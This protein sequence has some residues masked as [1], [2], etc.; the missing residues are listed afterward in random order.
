MF[1]KFLTLFILIVTVA[2]GF[3]QYPI[4][5]TTRPRIIADSARIAWMQA[6]AAVPGP[7]KTDFNNL[8]YNYTKGWITDPQLY[9][10]GNNPATWTWN[11]GNIWARTQ[12]MMTVFIYKI[13][14]DP[15]QLERCKFIG[16]SIIDTFYNTNLS[17]LDYYTKEYFL[18]DLMEVGNWVLD[19][20][21][22]DL[23]PAFRAQLVQVLFDIGTVFMNEYIYTPA[24]NVYVSSHN[25]RNCILNMQN[26]LTLYGA[27]GL[28]AAQQTTVTQWYQNLYDK[29]INGFIPCW[30]Y[31]R[32]DDGGW[33]WGVAYSMWGYPDQFEL[34]ENMRI[35]TTKNFFADLPWI[36]PSI[37]QYLYYLQ[38]DN[39][40]LHI[41]NG[42]MQYTGPDIVICLHA[43]HYNDPRSVWLAQFWSQPANITWTVPLFYKLLY[44]DYTAPVIQQPAIPLDWFS[45][46]VGLAVS[47]SSWKQ[48]ATMVSFFCAPVKRAAHEHRDNNSFIVF[49]NKPLLIDAGY[50]DAYNSS[51]FKNYYTRTIAHNS[52]CVF[53]STEAFYIYGTQ[54][55]SNDGGQLES[56][57]L[58]DINDILNPINK[59]GEWI[60]N[61]S[62]LNYQYNVADAHQ[63][64][65]PN[66]LDFFRRKLLFH[67]PDNILVVD[68]VHLLRIGTAQRDI[69]WIAHFVN[70]PVISGNVINTQVPGHI[71]TYNGRDYTGVNG[72]GSV[73]IRTLLPAQTTTRKVGG[74]G[75][76][77]YVNGVNYPTTYQ[78]D[79]NFYTPGSWRIEVRPASLPADGKV[80][81]MHTIKTG[82]AAQQAQPSG[83]ALQSAH[84]LGADWENTLYFF[85]ADGAVNKDYHILTDIQGSRTVHIMAADLQPDNYEIRLN[86]I[87]VATVATDTNGILQHDLTLPSGNHTIEILKQ[88]QTADDIIHDV[89]TQVYPNPADRYIVVSGDFLGYVY[90]ELIA[91]DG[92]LL[93]TFENQLNFD[94]SSLTPGMYMLRIYDK[95]GMRLYRFVKK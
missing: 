39:K 14:G 76:E 17:A 68:H 4:I 69:Q 24:G 13:A 92:R 84:S 80:V 94:I 54:P 21:Y 67:K 91:S 25:T 93:Q 57:S 59:R 3:A 72:N 74:A 27:S 63:S 40:C 16:Q 23:N 11:W 36:L 47:R 77:Y 58:I 52:I 65:N 75:Y 48:D 22:N 19:W 37:N 41:G 62:G 38:P 8:V 81:Y 87:V 30:S 29:F 70:E 83:L 78:P 55:I 64:Y 15:L 34:F 95:R 88:V 18:R 85:S 5:K 79:L 60:L 31:F 46:K 50:Y 44:K 82:T 86:N 1:R 43:R 51:H 28:T 26:V 33:N 7:Y 9:L 73:A 89:F 12:A 90:A 10:A 32:D 49:K 61:G 42:E 2:H 71:V 35:A 66:K 56:N 45:D 53:D 6:N 20:C